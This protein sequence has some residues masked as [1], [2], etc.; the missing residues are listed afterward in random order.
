M[1][2]LK[3]RKKFEKEKALPL[4]QKKKQKRSKDYI[5][6]LKTHL[7]KK[8]SISITAISLYKKTEKKLTKNILLKGN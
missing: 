7:W 1:T 5:S 4:T 3:V 2:V 8:V 6:I